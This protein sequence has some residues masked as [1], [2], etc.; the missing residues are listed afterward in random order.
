MESSPRPSPLRPHLNNVDEKNRAMESSIAVLRSLVIG[1]NVLVYGLFLYGHTPHQTFAI[2]ISVVAAAYA[3]WSL[4]FRPHERFP[5]LRYGVITIV[6][7]CVLITAWVIATGGP[8]SE[9]WAVYILSSVSAAMRYDMFGALLVGACESVTYVTA[10]T[11]IGGMRPSAAIVRAA[12]IILTA[13]AAGMLARVESTTRA[14]RGALEK[15]AVERE[16]LL[17]RERETVDALRTVDEMKSTFIS[18]ISHEIRTP[19]TSI[20]GFTTTLRRMDDQINES[21]RCMMLDAILRNSGRL[22]RMLVDLLDLNLMTA[23]VATAMRQPVALAD[24][25]DRIIAESEPESVGRALLQSV[26]PGLRPWIDGG[27]VERAI[28]NLVRNAIKYSP[29]GTPILI[30]GWQD[31][32]SLLLCVDDRGPGIPDDNKHEIFEQF[33]QGPATMPHSPG[34]GIGL[35]LVA[36]VARLHKGSAWVD[37]RE[38]G[39][40]SFAMRIADAF[41]EAGGLTRAS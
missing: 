10:M 28:D 12:Y 31:G 1:T 19:L 18:A 21:D 34:T 2:A 14:E 40:S 27:K 33:R 37:D 9:F 16:R 8:Q 23:G 6:A 41:P 5:L 20:V 24:L 29:D 3:V 13:L 22:E 38:D 39:G 7:D 17:S 30:R 4:G 32:N 11:I 26:D 35:A 15:N 36:Q 25:I